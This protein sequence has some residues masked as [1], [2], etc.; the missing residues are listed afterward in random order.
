VSD[1]AETLRAALSGRYT[2]ERE[3][4]RG[5]MATVW[6]ARDIRHDRHVA[7]KVLHP[8]LSA[9]LG[10]ERF[11]REIRTTARLDHPHILPLLDS[12]E[13]AA[14]PGAPGAAGGLL[15]YTMPFVEGESLRDRLRREGQLPVDQALR[16]AGEVADALDCAHEQGIVH[17]DIKPENILLSRAHAR[18]ADF[19]IARALEAAGGELTATGLAVG[20]PAYMSPEQAS[21]GAVDARSDVYALG[22]VLYE[23]LAGE[24]P[25]TGPTAQ[26]V[27]AKRF[28]GEP[29]P[30]RRVRPT[31]PEAVDQ[32]VRKALAPVPAD[33]FASA[34]EFA[35]ALAAAG[36]PSAPTPTAG[37]PTIAAPMPADAAPRRR[38]PVGLAT[39]GV[40]FV[41][42]LGVLFGWL[43]SHGGSGGGADESG[44]KRV[45]VLPFENLGRPDDEY[46]ADGLTDAVRGKLAALPNLQVS[47]RA[48]SAQYKRTAKSP[49]QIGRELGVQY[50]L[51]GTVRWQKGAAGEGRV[52]VSPELV[53]VTTASTKWQEPF[54]AS[55]TDVF[56]VQADVAT[57]VA[58][59]L[60]VAL[61]SGERERL[62][63]RPTDD[64]AAYDLYLRGNDYYERGYERENFRIARQML[65]RAVALDSGFALA[66]ARLSLVRAAEYWFFYERT[67]AALAGAKAAADQAL[68]LRPDLPEG[69]LALGYYWY[70]GR[71]DYD[72]ALRE[73]NGAQA[74]QPNDAD[75]AFAI[76]VVRRR[77]G[78]WKE[79]IANMTRAVEL[80][81]R[82]NVDLFNLA[83][84]YWLLRDYARAG[85]LLDNVI[86]L[87]PDWALAYVLKAQALVARGEPLAQARTV[88]H[89]ASDRLGF[90][91]LARAVVQNLNIIEPTFLVTGDPAFRIEIEALTLPGFPDSLGYYRLKSELYRLA[92]R[93]ELE[94]AYLDSARVALEV[95]V[96]E[97][98]DEAAF[99]ADL[100]LVYAYLGRPAEANREGEV[101]AQ[102]LTVARDAYKGGSILA[103]QALIESRTGR[104]DAAVDRLERLLA[105]PSAI[106][107]SLLRVDP[108]W[109]ALRDNARFQRLVRAE[110]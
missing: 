83:E 75:L 86:A 5:G 81:P 45:A 32:A 16:L 79:A 92:E 29:T 97:R 26:A 98:P 18:V 1:P 24:P 64:L 54:D 85:T 76:G 89:G 60:G 44:V 78:N 66:W 69:H 17:R 55:L 80:D 4:G 15:W 12:G 62:G 107:R 42:G 10:P 37:T 70:W 35:Q 87:A 34:A 100:G 14:T 106:S 58:Q 94:R 103:A 22:C 104:Q 95:K 56:Q 40:G 74:A 108:A 57:R 61:G 8:E 31:V 30:V 41:L 96:R 46:F 82:S 25:F 67:E 91:A 39:L 20:T 52:Q 65:E 101:G 102:L 49:A 51:T 38:V 84:T 105:V 21:G 13:V 72:Q 3:L 90:P 11:L 7:L 23:M 110:R 43:R 2:L 9:G 53:Q 59:A 93:P 77:Q 47:A 68:R 109:S 73:L 27:I 88:L 63:A 50:L 99:H 6:L 71:L 28:A 48:S 19:G 36:V 33:R